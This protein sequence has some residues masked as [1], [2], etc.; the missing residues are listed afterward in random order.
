MKNGKRSLGEVNKA[1]ETYVSAHLPPQYIE[2]HIDE[3]ATLDLDTIVIKQVRLQGT[4]R[5]VSIE[6]NY[7]FIVPIGYENDF[8]RCEFYSDDSKSENQ[9]IPIDGT[10]VSFLLAK[11]GNVIYAYSVDIVV[12][13]K[14]RNT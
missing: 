10:K 11:K 4:V 13:P 7:F 3:I 5:I 6:F 12:T 2:K 9:I 14:W 1:N 8:L